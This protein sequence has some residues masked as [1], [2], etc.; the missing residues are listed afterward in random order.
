MAYSRLVS[1]LIRLLIGN[2]GYGC[3]WQ[4]FAAA[5]RDKILYGKSTAPIPGAIDRNRYGSITIPLVPIP[6][7][8]IAADRHQQI[9]LILFFFLAICFSF[10]HAGLQ[11]WR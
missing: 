11:A 1:V 6:V 10:F 8:Y 3:R 4:F 2:A 7:K 9:L 5:S